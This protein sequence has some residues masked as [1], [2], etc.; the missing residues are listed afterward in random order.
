MNWIIS[1]NVND[2]DIFGAFKEYKAIFW[3]KQR[4]LSKSKILFIFIV[5]NLMEKLCLNAK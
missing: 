3:H 4:A 2:Y 5:E 1:C